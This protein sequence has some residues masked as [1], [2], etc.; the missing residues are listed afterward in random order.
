MGV[1][2]FGDEGEGGARAEVR[3]TRVCV[4]LLLGT[5]GGC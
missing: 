1:A 4:S 3:D 5:V 2:V